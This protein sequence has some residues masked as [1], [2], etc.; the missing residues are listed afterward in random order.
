MPSLTN[1][2]PFTPSAPND[3]TTADCYVRID[4]F[5]NNNASTKS[6]KVE[7]D[8][9]GMGMIST[10]DANSPK[11]ATNMRLS[12]SAIGNYLINNGFQCTSN[13]ASIYTRE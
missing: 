12:Q 3:M 6:F 9:H 10:A 4:Q 8:N 7:D 5:L 2:H 1:S 13:D 11:Y